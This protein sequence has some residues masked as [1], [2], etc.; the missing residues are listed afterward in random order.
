MK[1]SKR[2]STF[3]R[4]MD[5]TKFK[6]EFETEYKE[7]VLSEIVLQLMQEEGISVRKLAQATGISPSVVQDIR[8]GTRKNI[9]IQ[10]FL[11]VMK[12]LG[13]KV[14]VKIG[15]RYVSIGG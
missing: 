13:S 7:F 2:R 6:E 5:N 8:S 12:A 4:E 10:N 11:K 14:A 3:D 9:T 1:S 15:N